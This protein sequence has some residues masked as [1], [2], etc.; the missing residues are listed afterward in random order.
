MSKISES[1]LGYLEYFS[2]FCYFVKSNQSTMLSSVIRTDVIIKCKYYN[3]KKGIP[4]HREQSLL[5]CNCLL[6]G[7]KLPMQQ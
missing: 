5:G 2:K 4:L 6:K 1:M 3:I 7:K